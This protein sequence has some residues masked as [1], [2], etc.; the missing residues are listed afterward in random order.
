MAIFFVILTYLSNI[1]RSYHGNGIS[2]AGDVG[3]STQSASP[4]TR[5]KPSTTLV[6]EDRPWA[7]GQSGPHAED[8]FQP[9][10]LLPKQEVATVPGN[11][12][13]EPLRDGFVRRE[14]LGGAPGCSRFQQQWRQHQVGS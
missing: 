10:D 13:P 5:N 3:R 2:I 7:C 8:I 14:L 4:R 12:A 9:G 11:E 6:T 1:L